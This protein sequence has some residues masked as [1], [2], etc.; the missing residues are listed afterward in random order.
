MTRLDAEKAAYALR[1]AGYRLTQ[2]R[3]A[4]IQ[5]LQDKDEGLKPEEVLE[6]GRAVYPSLGLVTVYRTL[7]ILTQLGFVRRVHSEQRC[8]SYASAGLDRH[9]LICQR[10]HRIIEFPCNGLEALLEGVKEQTGYVITQHLLELDGLCP[11]C[12]EK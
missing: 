12:Q 6:Y 9:Y 1:E 2:P 3:L 7:E 10:C 8:H 4:V 11:A 5:V